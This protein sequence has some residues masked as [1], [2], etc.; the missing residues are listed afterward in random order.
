[1]SKHIEFL[2]NSVLGYTFEENISLIY[3]K[4][5][6][7]IS[8]NIRTYCENNKINL[9]T[10]EYPKTSSEKISKILLGDEYNIIIFALRKNLWHTP[11]RKKAK[12]DLKK[13]LVNLLHPDIPCDSYL[14]N[15]S[16][17]KKIGEQLFKILSE[18]ETITISTSCGTK[19][20]AKIGK[21]FCETGDYSTPASG[22]DFPAGEV[23]FGPIENSVYGKIFY[24]LKVQHIG[25][26]KQPI[27][28]NIN[29]DR[30]ILEKENKSFT[31]LISTHP[32]LEYISEISIGINPIWSITDNKLSII[33]EKNLGT[34]HFGHGANFSYGN[35]KGPHFD[36]VIQLP[37]II[38]D[39]LVVMKDGAFNKKYINH[40]A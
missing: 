33:E 13:R 34:V 4:D 17:M 2:I 32:M 19:V 31:R 30:I 40:L 26:I 14:A 15:I 20:N 3:D 6:S 1:M 24:D 28:I 35:R 39:D 12:Y 37:T 38:I 29:A 18:H 9:D 5:F 25:V 27:E 36:A 8:S 22:G 16:F 10:F 7:I 11:E 23:G 21:I